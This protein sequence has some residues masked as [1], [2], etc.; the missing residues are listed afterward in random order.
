M[1]V[2]GGGGD[3]AGEDRLRDPAQRVLAHVGAAELVG[4]DA[5]AVAP[6]L[7]QVH[8]EAL[9]DQH[10]EQVVGAAARE[11]EVA[12]DRGRRERRGV[13]GEQ[14]EQL[15]RLSGGGGVLSQIRDSTAR[16]LRSRRR[17]RWSDARHVHVAGHGRCGCAVARGRRRRRTRTVRPSSCRRRRWPRS[18]AA[19]P[20]RR[21]RRRRR[22]A[23]RRV[24]R[25][26]RTR[27]AAHPGREAPGA[28]AR[29]DPQPRRRL[30]A[31]RS[32]ARSCAR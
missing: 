7:G 6:L 5:E 14:L 22:A 4:A 27:D 30:A 31:T 12:R 23:L 11:V 10:V 32:S 1:R 16:E 18:R 13:A 15:Q 21:A 24:D 3:Q 26:R 25:V 17:A 28:A 19:A 9:V 8:D 29:P 2:V 20:C